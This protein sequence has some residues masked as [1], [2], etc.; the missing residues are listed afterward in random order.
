MVK[1]CSIPFKK[2]LTVHVIFY[3]VDV[4][5]VLKLSTFLRCSEF[6]TQSLTQFICSINIFYILFKFCDFLS[7][8]Y[9]VLSKCYKILSKCYEI[10]DLKDLVRSC[11][12]SIHFYQAFYKMCKIYEPCFAMRAQQKRKLHQHKKF[13]SNQ[14]FSY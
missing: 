14:I 13:S 2:L 7:T 5:N 6:N 8:F 9:D 3:Y 12:I 10:L 1:E 4:L 11:S